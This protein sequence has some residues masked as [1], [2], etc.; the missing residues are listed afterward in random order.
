MSEKRPATRLVHTR[1]ARL[2]PPTVNPPV[3]RASTVLFDD[4]DALYDARPGYGRMGLTVQRELEDA[5]ATLEGAEHVRLAPSGLAACA[6]AIAAM[7]RCGDHV[8]I[9]DTLYGPTRRFCERRLKAMGVEVTRFAPRIGAGIES[10]IH[11]D[12]RAIYLESPGSLT[13]EVMDAPA[14]ADVARARG[15]V[16][17]MDNTWSGGLFCQPLDLGID[18]SVQALTKYAVGHSDAF[19]GAVMC[20]DGA[21][22]QRLTDCA[23][24][25]GISLGPEEA[26]AALRGL[27]T[28]PVRLAAHQT[29]GLAL[30]EWL[31]ARPQVAQVLHPALPD[32]PDHAIWTRDYSG[33][34]GLFGFVLH[35]QSEGAVEAF[36][37][38]LE[39]FSMGF[40]WGG[41]ESLLIS[42]DRQ[43][44]R[45]KPDWTGSRAGPLMRVHAGLEDT[46]DLIGDLEQAF[47]H[48]SAPEKGV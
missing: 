28:L 39:L 41:F 2:S 8:L 3:E 43:L 14:I 5:L 10:L 45:L 29:A 37:R 38:A 1:R 13:F 15:L 20:R 7:V 48:L 23:E 22:A 16:T 34:S 30:A 33:A 42:C 40:S 31:V 27:R 36:L 44:T 21:I 25:W 35:R 32:H 19:G 6:L 26:Y 47:R 11:A 24:D 9:A 4:P 17:V 12:T 46:G 18:I